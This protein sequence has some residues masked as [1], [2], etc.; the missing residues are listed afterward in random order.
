[1]YLFTI[2][3]IPNLKKLNTSEFDDIAGALVNVWIDF[4]E[5]EAAEVLA[6]FYIKKENWIDQE[7]QEKPVWVDDV[8]TH[9]EAYPFFKE[10]CE[11]GSALVFNMIPEEEDDE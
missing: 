4:P 3:A 6:R 2:K 7:S 1:M 9:D 5:E 11:Y 8:E 10:A